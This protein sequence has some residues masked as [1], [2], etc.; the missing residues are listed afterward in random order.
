[1]AGRSTDSIK[2]L[3]HGSYADWVIRAGDRDWLAFIDGNFELCRSVIRLIHET[4]G[5]DALRVGCTNTGMLTVFT[6]H[7]LLAG[8]DR[9]VERRVK[10][11]RDTRSLAVDIAESQVQAATRFID[12]GTL[13]QLATVIC[14]N[15]D[16]IRLGF[17]ELAL[18]MQG[19]ESDEAQAFDLQHQYREILLNADRYDESEIAETNAKLN[20]LDSDGRRLDTMRSRLVK[21][22]QMLSEQLASL[23]STFEQLRLTT[24]SIAVE[25]FNAANPLEMSPGLMTRDLGTIHQQLG[26]E[27]RDRILSI[28]AAESTRELQALEQRLLALQEAVAPQKSAGLEEFFEVDVV[29]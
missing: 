8:A 16:A 3:L 24:A 22:Q 18:K 19:L 1:M 12:H 20:A 17:D 13:Q 21:R 25:T 29:D 14:R 26:A 23:V 7:D 27:N 5:G 4:E 9:A 10:L 2:E 28:Q 11:V 6:R 15:I